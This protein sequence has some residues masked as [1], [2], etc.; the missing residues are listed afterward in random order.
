M[1]SP[2]RLLLSLPAVAVL[3]FAGAACS[4]SDN[5]TT[6]G[7]GSTT[8]ASTTEGSTVATTL[9][10]VSAPGGSSSL[11]GPPRCVTADLSITVGQV[12]MAAGNRYTP[13][14][15]ANT[16]AHACTL[17]GYPGIALLDAA[18]KQIGKPA[19][20]ES[21]PVGRVVLAPAGKASAA[22]HTLNPAMASSCLS[23][24]VKVQVIVPD[25]STPVAVPAVIDLC[26]GQLSVLPIVAG[27]S[28][29]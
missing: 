13:I 29:A 1:R 6:T 16:S 11:P 17:R 9:P 4:S 28:G 18:G 22:V 12:G 10:A 7:G 25:E 8:S 2:R 5:Q 23:P 3:T 20:R 21:H 19:S 27:T 14:V 26:Q 24:S 15:F